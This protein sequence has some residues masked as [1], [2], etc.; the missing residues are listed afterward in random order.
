MV[1]YHKLYVKS[2]H[3]VISKHFWV[4]PRCAQH[5][6]STVIYTRNTKIIE[7]DKHCMIK[8]LYG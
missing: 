8:A 2:G 5:T 1:L 3:L 7:I 4:V 6:D